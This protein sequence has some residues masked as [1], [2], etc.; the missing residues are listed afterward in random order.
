MPL[1]FVLKQHLLDLAASEAKAAVYGWGWWRYT[2]NVHDGT[3]FFPRS[4][5]TPGE[6]ALTR[7]VTRV[8]ETC[9]PERLP[10]VLKEMPWR[11]ILRERTF[12]TILT[13]RVPSR[14]TTR[15][16][17]TAIA[18]SGVRVNLL[19]PDVLVDVIVT[20]RVA[21]IGLRARE[22]QGDFAERRAHLLP[23]PHP[24]G[25]HPA[26]ARALLSL[27]AA[28]TIHDPFCGAGGILIEAGLAGIRVSGGDIKEEMIRRARQNCSAYGLHPEL[29]VADAT[30]WVPRCQA[31][32][33]DLPYGKGTRPVDLNAL[34]TAFLDRASTSTRR[35]VIGLPR[36]LPPVRSW[37]VR[38]HFRER[39]HRS[40]TRH[41]FVLE[42]VER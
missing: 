21:Y 7:I 16:I 42:R 36:E 24:T 3:L 19:Q 22:Y 33:T 17:A 41:F 23:A 4:R 20:R 38:K 5:K 28:K 35:V 10:E 39:V 8:I 25:M 32:V 9:R 34:V 37:A 29:K 27:V 6:L 13:R 1:L 31:I 30:A 26:T 12:K 14:V 15:A 40:L 11:R 2:R 18:R